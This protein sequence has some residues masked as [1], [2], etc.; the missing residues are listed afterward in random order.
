MFRRLI[1]ALSRLKSNKVGPTIPPLDDPV[2]DDNG[3][4]CCVILVAA[5]AAMMAL[6]R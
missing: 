3:Y 6:L 5:T 2:S 4:G 1:R